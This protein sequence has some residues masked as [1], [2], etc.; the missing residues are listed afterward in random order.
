MNKLRI[1]SLL[2]LLLSGC[3]L[4]SPAPPTA[5]PTL[6]ATQVYQTVQAKL[7]EAIAL[8]QSRLPTATPAPSDTPVP[9][10]P[11]ATDTPSA[12]PA[13]T[14]TPS[15]PT[16]T[17]TAPCDQAAPGTPIDVTIPDDTE[18]YPGQVFVKTW[19]LVNAGTCPWTTDYKAVWFSGEQMGAPAEVALPSGVAP[20]E[21]VDISV[22][23]TA[24]QEPGTY[25]SNWKL[26]NAGGVIFGIGPG[27][28]LPFYVRIKVVLI[29]TPTPTATPTVTLLPTKTPQATPSAH[30]SGPVTLL[31]SDTLDL[32]T[33]LVNSAAGMDLLYTSGADDTPQL[34]PQGG[35]QMAV[36]GDT[37]PELADCQAAAL[38][39]D[40]VAVD[41]IAL[42]TY[43]C[44]RTDEGRFGWMRVTGYL[45]DTQALNLSIFTW[46]AQ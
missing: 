4:L 33:N 25:Q 37:K 39:S 27:E 11:Q 30:V 14:D 22:E 21:S 20:G 38:S 32:D 6:N 7:T 34:Q 28:G 8:T 44:Y 36:F 18:M 43:L 29:N 45:T 42:G 9:P 17:P 12:L 3:T 35:A 15:A 1:L 16:A 5:E 26:R 40:P 13:A 10:P 46:E 23:M 19:R 2:A 31:I 24:P 41:S